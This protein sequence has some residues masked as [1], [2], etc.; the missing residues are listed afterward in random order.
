MIFSESELICFNSM[1]DGQTI[2]GTH[3]KAPPEPD[4]AYVRQTVESLKKKGFLDKDEN[5]NE[6]FGVAVLM[7]KAYKNAKNYL[8]INKAR[9]ALEDQKVTV[10]TE[11]KDGFDLTRTDKAM[12]FEALLRETPYLLGKDDGKINRKTLK[13]D[14]WSGS[15]EDE[16]VLSD[17]MWLHK[18]EDRA[19]KETQIMYRIDEQG[20]IYSPDKEELMECGPREMRVMLMNLFEIQKAG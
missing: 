6:L 12:F 15:I 17:N 2:L 3:F 11:T 16:A 8:F 20:Y 9:I 13:P 4:E 7:L 10:L 18:F 19:L 1:I 14:A 5:P